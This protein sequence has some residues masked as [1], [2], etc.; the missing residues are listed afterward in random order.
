MKIK[1]LHV[2]QLMGGL[3]DVTSENPITLIQETCRKLHANGTYLTSMATV[4]DQ[5]LRDTLLYHTAMGQRVIEL[6]QQCQM[7]L[8]GIGAL[9]AGR[10]WRRI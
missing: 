9:N 1:N 6:W 3:S 8:F 2:V 10:C 4:D 5:T 7:A